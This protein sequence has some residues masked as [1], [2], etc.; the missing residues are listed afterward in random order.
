MPFSDTNKLR[1]PLDYALRYVD[2]GI[3]VIP[4]RRDGSKVPALGTWAEFQKRFPSQP[5]IERWWNVP[6]PPGIAAVCGRISGGLMLLDFDSGA[7][8]TWGAF[9][10]ILAAEFPGLP[11]LLTLVETPRQPAGLHAW[12]RVPLSAEGRNCKLAMGYSGGGKPTVKIET[13]GE[14]GYGL[15]PGS[16]GACHREGRTYEFLGGSTF[17]NL[18]YLT[19]PEFEALFRCARSLG[20]SPTVD[21]PPTLSLAGGRPGEEFDRAG[22]PWEDILGPHGWWKV[23]EANGIGYWLRPGKE[24]KGWSA[25]TAAC[26]GADGAEL[27]RVFSSN[28]PPFEDGKSYGKFR[29][30]AILNHGGDLSRA[31]ADLARQ[32]Y[33]SPRPDP[34][35]AT[36]SP[37]EPAQTVAVQE[38]PEKTQRQILREIADAAKLFRAPDGK[39]YA[40][41]LVGPKGQQYLKVLP[42]DGGG[43]G[44]WLTAKFLALSGRA[45]QPDALRDMLDTLAALAEHESPVEPL[46][47]RVAPWNDG[48]SVLDLCRESG[49]CVL[50]SAKGWE[51]SQQCPVN[52]KRSFVNHPL[53]VPR[54]N[55]SIA[56]LWDIVNLAE[57]DR[58]LVACWLLMTLNPRGPFPLLCMHGE[59]GSGKSINSRFIRTLVDPLYGHIRR[60]PKC[61]DDIFV[62]ASNSWIYAIENISRLDQ[63]MSDALCCVST[64]GALSRRRLYSNFEEA[65]TELRRPVL[66]NGIGEVTHAADLASRALLVTCPVVPDSRRRVESELVRCF[67][68]YWAS[69][70]GGLLTAYAQVLERLPKL[71][72][73]PMSRLADFERVSVAGEEA[74][75]FPP[76]TFQ[77]RFL[78]SRD[79]AA[80]ASLE[81]SVLAVAFVKTLDTRRLETWEGSASALL[82]MVNEV[83][84]GMDKERSWPR[85]PHHFSQSLRRLSPSLRKAGIFLEFHRQAGGGRNRL[86]I[87]ERA[88]PEP[89]G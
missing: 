44:K 66:L 56:P 59:Q 71:D 40:R 55:G 88:K 22:P 77:N 18:I 42:F 32:G 57:Q 9:S 38:P 13:R 87:I 49:E 39:V 64:G 36:S 61:E 75:G 70:L 79:E 10:A 23:R 83:N 72:A 60:P 37:A 43:V 82:Q 69:I 30:Y 76:G 34:A 5:E 41:G 45:P 3:S 15:L 51:V 29:A 68:E 52:F 19:E 84:P 85:T 62:T 11:H 89:R 4:I 17:D 81:A 20:E 16:P 80:N 54:R 86:I 21:H 53:P 63:D 78:E 65:T 25:T 1:S 12:F 74:L 46:F 48:G 33:G 35:T 47:V 24:G 26:H 7:R 6:N 27:F 2:A 58:V 73:F 50:I 67:E 31:A 28:A 14:G 8:E